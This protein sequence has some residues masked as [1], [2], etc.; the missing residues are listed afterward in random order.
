M[1]LTGD[2]PPEVTERC[3]ALLAADEL[4]A[5]QRFQREELRR[6]WRCTRAMVRMVLSNY[7]DVAPED[8]R[9][10][11]TSLGKPELVG[12][13]DLPLTFNLAHSGRMIL[14]GVEGNVGQKAML[15][16]DIER[17]RRRERHLALARRF[18]APDEVAWLESQPPGQQQESFFR[19]WTL[20]EAYL[21][22]R[23]TGLAL[24]LKGFS[25]RI[26]AEGESPSVEFTERCPDD[27]RRWQ[28][29]E[30]R[31][32]DSAGV[33]D[34]RAAVARGGAEPGSTLTVHRREFVIQPHQ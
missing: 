16:V 34:Y 20:K 28:F 30:L 9:F 25:I 13:A 23:G 4:A 29:V 6:R 26:A 22:A 31:E 14:C 18:F 10:H 8:W 19:I 11:R 33:D 5:E 15:G 2:E 7:A 17:V 27:P 12:P 32:R 1:S 24:P 21:K 3:R